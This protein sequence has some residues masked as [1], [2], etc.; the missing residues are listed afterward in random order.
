MGKVGGTTRY[1]TTPIEIRTPIVIAALCTS[2]REKRHLRIRMSLKITPPLDSIQS[3]HLPMEELR[4]ALK[5][6]RAWVLGQPF[7]CLDKIFT[8]WVPIGMFKDMQL[9]GGLHVVKSTS[10]NIGERT[11]ITFKVRCTP[12]RASEI[13]PIREE[14]SFL[15]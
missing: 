11:K 13:L 5:C 2:Q 12:L 14:D 9:Q 8:K 7:G 6:P 3:L 1:N 10:W 4:F 15:V